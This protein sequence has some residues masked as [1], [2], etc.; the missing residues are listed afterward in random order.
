MNTI[1]YALISIITWKWYKMSYMIVFGF[2]KIWKFSKFLGFFFNAKMYEQCNAWDS[3]KQ[4]RT[5]GEIVG[6]SSKLTS[7][8]PL[9]ESKGE[10]KTKRERIKQNL[11]MNRV[12]ITLTWSLAGSKEDRQRKHLLLT[13]SDFDWPLK[14]NR[15]QEMAHRR[16]Y[17]YNPDHQDHTHRR[18]IPWIRSSW[19]TQMVSP[20][21]HQPSALWWREYQ[22]YS[23]RTYPL[24]TLLL[25]PP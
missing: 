9:W 12:G 24:K 15:R 20:S 22:N 21:D 17:C 7:H 1:L 4:N 3:R 6:L 14:D 10:E 25:L 23:Q 13:S 2:W 18:T 11:S 8:S 16:P 5:Q 19:F